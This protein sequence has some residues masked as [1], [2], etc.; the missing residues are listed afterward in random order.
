MFELVNDTKRR[1]G[2]YCGPTAIGLLTGVPVSRIEKMIRR[3]RGGYRDVDGK[4]IPVR[5]TGNGE[6]IAV[7]EALGCKVEKAKVTAQTFG[8]FVDDVRHAGAFLVNVTGHYM[9]CEAGMM[10]DTRNMTPIP[11]EQYG[12]AT[13]RVQRAWKVTAPET[14]RYTVNDPLTQVREKK[15][16]PDIKVVRYERAI[17]SLK[18]WQSKAKRA[19]TAVRRYRKQ[20]RYYERAMAAGDN[21]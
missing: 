6:V 13:W 15:P 4:R 10:A 8:R 9:V 18:R 2:P 5:G 14:P 20:V 19:E 12:R 17:A 7:L 3:R 11:I 16:K 21:Q 1:R